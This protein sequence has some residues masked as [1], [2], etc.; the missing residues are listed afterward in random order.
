MGD[1][2]TGDVLEVRSAAYTDR[3]GSRSHIIDINPSNRAATL[4]VD[5]CRPSSLMADSYDCVIL[6]QTLQFLEAPEVA[7][8]NLWRSLRPG[9]TMMITVPCAVRIDHELP[10]ADYWRWIPAGLRELIG[11]HCDEAMVEVEGAGNLV[12]ALAALL[13]RRSAG[14]G[15]CCRRCRL[16]DHRLR[17]RQE[18]VIAIA[19]NLPSPAT[20]NI[21]PALGW[22]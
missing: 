8:I 9:G 22:A 7:L 1:R 16:P 2:I 3:F 4:V 10:E 17:R 14:C 5:L 20:S 12:T 13:G 19:P 15:P 21:C 11:R 6:T 18:A